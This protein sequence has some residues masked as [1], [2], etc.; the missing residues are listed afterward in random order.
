MDD[1]FDLNDSVVW[2]IF[3]Q[4]AAEAGPEGL[5]DLTRLWHAAGR[6]KGYSPRQY[7][8]KGRRV[9]GRILKSEGTQAD[10]PAWATA[11]T[12]LAYVEILDVRVYIFNL[13]IICEQLER[14]PVKMLMDTPDS[15]KGLMA[16]I[17]K[18]VVASQAGVPREDADQLIISEAIERTE[19]LNPYSQETLVASVGRAVR[20][21]PPILRRD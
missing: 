8:R 6:P 15:A 18:P 2:R 17:V 10:S 14:D 16:C 19:N 7:Y 3:K 4:L 1:N 21:E 5:I 9:F 12:A 20:G 11:E 13:N